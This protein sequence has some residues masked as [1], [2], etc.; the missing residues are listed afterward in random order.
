V[1]EPKV[2]VFCPTYILD[3][4]EQI[5]PRTRESIRKLTF[6]SGKMVKVI[7][8]D[9]HYPP[10]DYRNVLHQYRKAR[11]RVLRG[12]YDALL[13]I[14]HDIIAPPDALQQL[15]DTG[16][17]VAYGIYLFRGSRNVVNAFRMVNGPN[18][19]MSLS[20]FPELLEKARRD[21]VIEASGLGNGCT[22]I[23]REVLEKIDFREN[24]NDDS[25]IPDIPFSRDC[26]KEG[27][28]QVAHFGV[29]CGHIVSDKILWFNGNLKGV[30]SSMTRVKI[31]NNF[32]GT[33]GKIYT[34]GQ[35]TEMSMELVHDYQRAGFVQ[36]LGM[37]PKLK[38]WVVKQPCDEK[39]VIAVRP[40]QKKA[41]GLIQ[42]LEEYGFC[43]VRV[44]EIGDALLIDHDMPL[45]DYREHI[46][47]YWRA[48][49]PVF[50][51]PHGAAPVLSWDGMH[52]PCSMVTANFVTGK[53]H[54]EVMRRYDYPIPTHVIG[55]YLCPTLPW[56]ETDG[57]NVLFGPIHP[58]MGHKYMYPEDVK[59]NVRTYERLL[60]IPNINLTVRHVGDLKIN[61][62][63]EAQGVRILHG[64]ADNNYGNID[65]ADLIIS[66]GTLAYMAIARGKPTIMLGQDTCGRD[67]IGETVVRA[68][69]MGKYADYMRFPF[70]VDDHADLR[71]VMYEAC[72][73]EP[74]AWKRKFIGD[75]L[76]VQ[77][78]GELVEELISKFNG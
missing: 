41:E 18:P 74:I 23:R 61:G 2:L 26:M 33:D 40:I 69:S 30:N 28:K 60:E 14:E 51:Y 59:A 62:L 16:A 10:P 42:A 64:Q 73:R 48:G 50:L 57:Y 27:F 15:W 19:D 8:S 71:R 45:Y 3:G 9:S 54:K 39:P 68:K 12:G 65:E 63:W 7:S 67:V 1:T 36:E 13:T 4:V 24:D 21:V 20:Q 35:E 44:P 32:V 58:V 29:Q 11:K 17:P 25:P 52:E 56:A 49:K 43:V 53:G 31:L 70:D 34:V 72:N 77:R 78:F 22:L 46:E 75:P 38:P 5:K 76:D 55:W 6:C 47:Q 37:R 66:N